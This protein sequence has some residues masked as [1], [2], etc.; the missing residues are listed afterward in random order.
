MAYGFRAKNDSNQIQIDG[1][2][3]NYCFV[4]GA[5]NVT[6]TNGGGTT[7]YWTHISV[8]S[9]TKPPLILFQPNT[10]AFVTIDSYSK[11]GNSYDGFNAVTQHPNTGDS[12]TTINWKK[13]L[14]T[15]GQSTDTYGLRVYNDSNE[16]VYDSGKNYFKI[17][18][19]ESIDIAV[20]DSPV[21]ITHSGIS[22][23][24]YILAP[25][26]FWVIAIPGVSIR[27]F[28][29]GL[30]KI[31]STQVSV[32]WFYYAAGAYSPGSPNE[33]DGIAP[34]FKLIICEV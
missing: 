29:V 5:S 6:V 22:D 28:K 18:S 33:N 4:E 13:Y 15:P 25:T 10:D 30:K 16:T 1:Q 11:T 8:T 34:T 19:V 2:N 14:P 26:G 27:F 24:Y 9:S 7:N 12:S 20:D 17:H 3:P 21:T 31:S 23:P 32:G